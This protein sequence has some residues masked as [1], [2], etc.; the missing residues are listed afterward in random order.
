MAEELFDPFQV[1]HG[2]GDRERVVGPQRQQ[3]SD[4]DG[5]IP[6]RGMRGAT[7]L[8]IPVVGGPTGGEQHGSVTVGAEGVDGCSPLD[9]ATQQA[10]LAGDDRPME[11]RVPQRVAGS[12]QLGMVPNHRLNLERVAGDDR[13]PEALE[14]G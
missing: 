6:Q 10:E 12:H 14:V 7:G 4:Q 11:S 9:E 1:A 5:G 8:A 2:S 3:A 13:L